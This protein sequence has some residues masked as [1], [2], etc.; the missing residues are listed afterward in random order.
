[1][2]DPQLPEEAPVA[3]PQAQ[4]RQFAGLLLVI[5]GGLFAWSLYRHQGK[6]TVVSAVGLIVALAVGLPGLVRPTSIRPV[7]LTAVAVTRPIGHVVSATL[8]GL[9][10]FLLLA[11]LALLFRLAGHDPLD[12]QRTADATYWEPKEQPESIQRYLRQ[13]QQQ[14]N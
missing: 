1:M 8:M 11:P 4:L 9:I 13:Y 10:Y 14:R 7:F 3:L 12:R 6:P 2:I 5:L